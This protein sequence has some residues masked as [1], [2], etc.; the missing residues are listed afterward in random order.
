MNGGNLAK[1]I[2]K[3]AEELLELAREIRAESTNGGDG[4]KAEAS[5]VGVKH[6]KESQKLLEMLATFGVDAQVVRVEKGAAVT[7]VVLQLPPGVRYS[8]VTSL[9]D[10]LTA[11][12]HGCVRVEAPVYGED[13]VA[14]EMPNDN[15]EDVPLNALLK[16]KKMAMCDL[17]LCLGKRSDGKDVVV[18]LTTLPHLLVGGATG[19]GKTTLLNAIICGLIATHTPREVK[20]VLGDPK[21]IEFVQYAEL[22]HLLVPILNDSRKFVFTLQWAAEEME[23]RFKLFAQARCRNV[24]EYNRQA[25]ERVPYVVFVVDELSEWMDESAKETVP[26]LIR[27]TAKGRAAGIHLILSTQHMDANVVPGTVKANILGRIAFKTAT[28][29]DS[30]AL[31]DAAGAED[32][33]GRGDMLFKGKNGKIVRVQAGYVSDSEIGTFMNY[34]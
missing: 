8:S 3:I 32:L 17:P 7:R 20:L 34:K 25:K 4:V 10:N 24:L 28:S 27:L 6:G 2:E 26:N 22:P 16:S 1:R 31:L 30:Q 29:V 19:Q 9:K 21:C 12:F 11:A 13:A 14:V 23:K 15:R 18:D 5:A 33:L